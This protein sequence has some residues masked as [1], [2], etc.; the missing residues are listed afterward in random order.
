MRIFLISAQRRH[1]GERT[2][3]EVGTGW[4]QIKY[5]TRQYAIFPQPVVC[6]TG[7]TMMLELL[8]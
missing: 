3:A 4:F 5:P 1:D 2:T 7:L 8:Q 6:Y